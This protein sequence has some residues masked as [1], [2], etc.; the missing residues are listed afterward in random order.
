M[1][2]NRMSG[3]ST[4]SHFLRGVGVGE[5]VVAG[6]RLEGE[7]NSPMADE[8]IEKLEEA[9]EDKR[10]VGILLEVESPGGA[11]VPSQEMY[12]IITRIK[13]A[14]PVVAYIRDVAASGAYYTIAPA[15]R[16]VANRGSMVGSIG[17]VLETFEASE[18]IAWAK[19]KPITLKTGKLKDAGSP[20]RPYSEDD[21][22]YLQSLI[23]KTR[24]QFADDVKKARGLSDLTLAHMSDGRVVLGTEAANLK[25]ID[26]VG[27]RDDALDALEELTKQKPLP[28]VYYMEET[29]QNVPLVF[30]YLFE[31]ASHSLGRGIAD[32]IRGGVDGALQEGSRTR[33]P[34]RR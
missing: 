9:E 3:G 18:L 29:T 13:A 10:V 19:L 16:I 30:R 28:E 15:S 24:A 12:D 7:I 32:G 14:K 8:V 5:N 33:A 2:P 31:E 25:L 21:K 27:N 34:L 22:A 1:L 6:I 26:K 23:D 4:K 20:T 17:V 11:V